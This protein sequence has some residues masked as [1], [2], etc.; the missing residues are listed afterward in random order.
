MS[1]YK[2]FL[3]IRL[4][5]NGTSS[6]HFNETDFI[7]VKMAPQARLSGQTIIFRFPELTRQRQIGAWPP[8]GPA[9]PSHREG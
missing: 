1:G 6:L 4:L 8:P 7:V 5:G 9:G 2:V 3:F